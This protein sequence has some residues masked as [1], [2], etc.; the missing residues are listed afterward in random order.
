MAK[1][2][3]DL[4]VETHTSSPPRAFGTT[5]IFVDTLSLKEL[6]ELTGILLKDRKL[7]ANAVEGVRC[8]EGMWQE[9]ALLQVTCRQGD[10]AVTLARA[11]LE[12]WGY[13]IREVNKVRQTPLQAARHAYKVR[14]LGRPWR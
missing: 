10:I 2:V 7:A 11:T 14:L 3:L 5:N 9:A 12:E 13:E 1:K 6:V 8:T 4:C